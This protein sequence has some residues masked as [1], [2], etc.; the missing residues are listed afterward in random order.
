MSGDY[1][2]LKYR[3]VVRAYRPG[4]RRQA[5]CTARLT[6]PD[7]LTY[8]SLIVT[9]LAAIVATSERV[10]QTSRRNAKIA[11][12]AA[13]LRRLAP[14]EIETAVAFLAGE[15]RQG[16]IGSAM[17]CCARRAPARTPKRRR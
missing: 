16:R 14:D 9:L 3:I 6:R 13:C 2:L 11:E 8:R 1:L 4:E 10:A 5:P 7:D 12:I 15:R 17:R